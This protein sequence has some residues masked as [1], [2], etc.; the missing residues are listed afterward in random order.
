[1]ALVHSDESSEGEPNEGEEAEAEEE[2]RDVADDAVG[3]DDNVMDGR[4]DVGVERSASLESEA[5][6]SEMLKYEKR[7]V[8]SAYK[9]T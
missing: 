9:L 3:D 6:G 5:S 4:W 2:R 1:L 7:S 8:P